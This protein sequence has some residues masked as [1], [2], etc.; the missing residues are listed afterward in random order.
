VTAT[1]PNLKDAVVE[2][3]LSIYR[4]YIQSSGPERKGKILRK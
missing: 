4:P 3:L 2:N 1:E